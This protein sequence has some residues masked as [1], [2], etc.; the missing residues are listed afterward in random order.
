MIIRVNDAHIHTHTNTHREREREQDISYKFHHW[1]M[2]SYFF[3]TLCNRYFPQLEIFVELV[4]VDLDDIG[5]FIIRRLSLWSSVLWFWVLLLKRG[6]TLCAKF[7]SVDRCYSNK[8]FKGYMQYRIHTILLWLLQMKVNPESCN[9]AFIDFKLNIFE[10]CFWNVAVYGCD[11]LYL[12][13]KRV[14]FYH[15]INSY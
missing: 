4:V 13:I 5:S 1:N 9:D 8:T 11:M 7:K 14:S 3:K 2:K 15:T 12:F 10:V 6:F